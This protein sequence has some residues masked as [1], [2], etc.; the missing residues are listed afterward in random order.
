MHRTD[1]IKIARTIREE[2]DHQGDLPTLTRLAASLCDVFEAEN[3]KFER[4]RFFKSCFG[5]ESS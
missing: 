1:Y 5:K 3:A 2:A 4:K